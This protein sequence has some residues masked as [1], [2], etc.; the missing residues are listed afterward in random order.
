[1]GGRLSGLVVVETTS[2][3]GRDG[4][5]VSFVHSGRAGH[6]TLACPFWLST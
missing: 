6:V 3:Q 1:M 4:R 2:D 5:E